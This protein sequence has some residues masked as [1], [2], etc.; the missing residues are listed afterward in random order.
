MAQIFETPV[1]AAFAGGLEGVTDLIRKDRGHLLWHWLA[2][3]FLKAHLKHR[4]L[5]WH[6]NRNLGDARIADKYDWSEL[7]HIH[8]VVRSFHT[9]AFLQDMVYG[10]VLVVP[11]SEVEGGEQFDFANVLDGASIMLRFGG[12]MVIAVLNDSRI[13]LNSM[14]DILDKITG[15][16]TMLQGRE[17]MAKICHWN[18]SFE[19]RPEYVSNIDL[20]TGDYAIE[21]VLP[22][23]VTLFEQPRIELYGKIL[24]FFVREI[25]ERTGTDPEIIQY[26][27]EGR[28]SFLF[29]EDGGFLTD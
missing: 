5:R 11:A 7:Y 16:L 6:L 4:E 3:I 17:L 28:Y 25:L 29:K 13:V 23:G 14:I 9:G 1:S 24:H 20:S 10:S 27:R 2:L 18:L 19:P 15:P 8:C 26:V 12:V 22:E 21:S